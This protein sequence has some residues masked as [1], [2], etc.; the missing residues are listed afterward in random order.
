MCCEKT[1][2]EKNVFFEIDDKLLNENGEWRCDYPTKENERYCIF[3]KNIEDKNK[4]KV[5][6]ELRRLISKK[7]EVNIF[8]G[9]FSDLNLS[10]MKIHGL[11]LKGST[12]HGYVDFKT[13][14]FLGKASFTSSVFKDRVN[15]G[16]CNFIYESKFSYVTFESEAYFTNTAFHQYSEFHNTKFEGL[17]VFSNS[18]LHHSIFFESIFNSRASFDDCKFKGVNF[19]WTEFSNDVS[20]KNCNFEKVSK[21]YLNSYNKYKNKIKNITGSEFKDTIFFNFVKFREYVDFSNSTFKRNADFSKSRIDGKGDLSET[22]FENVKFVN[23]DLSNSNLQGLSFENANFE[24]AILEG[25]KLGGI[26]FQNSKLNA[27]KFR[28][29]SIDSETKFFNYSSIFKSFVRK[30]ISYNTH[31]NSNLSDNL[32]DKYNTDA[33]INVYSSIEQLGR[34]NGR[35]KVES[36]AFINRKDVYL[37]NAKK[38]IHSKFKRKFYFNTFIKNNVISYSKYDYSDDLTEEYDKHKMFWIYSLIKYIKL[39]LSR[40][41]ILYGESPHRVIL[42]SLLL[43]IITSFIY[44]FVGLKLNP[45]SVLTYTDSKSFL[46]SL[47]FSILTFTNLGPNYQVIGFGKIVQTINSV[48]G[49]VLIALFVFVLGRRAAR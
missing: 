37:R 2:E 33:K 32:T 45:N 30:I 7:S 44:P 3:H 40:S 46:H 15:F 8:E 29:S 27:A 9:K 31:E 20:F 19:I 48:F 43:I 10:D 26:N 5:E 13:S 39:K 34:E 4:E 12:F 42:T 28:G 35:N 18:V 6:R 17:T 23:A 24:G 38:Q 16:K 47:Y 49:A 14:E 41:V 11:Q 21:N 1:I 22:D 36:K 25:S